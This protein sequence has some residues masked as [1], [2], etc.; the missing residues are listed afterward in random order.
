MQR[1][2]PTTASNAI[3]VVIGSVCATAIFAAAMSGLATAGDT[4]AREGHPSSQG[5][6]ITAGAAQDVI[7]DVHDWG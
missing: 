5:T 1:V 6:T 3:H 2:I 7:D 4:L